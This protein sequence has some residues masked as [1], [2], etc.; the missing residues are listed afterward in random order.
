MQPTFR[1]QLH[2][3]LVGR[4]GLGAVLVFT[5]KNRRLAA[6]T[7]AE[8][9]AVFI[10]LRYRCYKTVW[11]GDYLVVRRSVFYALRELRLR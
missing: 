7:E 4:L 6:K 8:V 9:P 2:R 10:T 5:N 1:E 3:L 11:I